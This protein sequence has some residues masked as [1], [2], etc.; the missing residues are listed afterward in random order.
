MMRRSFGLFSFLATLTSY[1]WVSCAAVRES[2]LPKDF[3]N[4]KYPDLFILG[5]QKCATTVLNKMMERHSTFCKYGDKEKHYFTDNEWLTDAKI[6]EFLGQFKK[7]G[8]DEMTVDATPSMIAEDVVPDRVKSTYPPEI[9]AKKKFVVLF[10]EPAARHYSGYQRDVR[11][12]LMLNSERGEK[13]GFAEKAAKLCQYILH[14]A[15]EAGEA[16]EF[17][18]TVFENK[19][20]IEDSLLTF[21]EWTH[22]DF[23][24]KQLKRGYFL[25]QLRNW[26]RV[27]DRSQLF[28]ISF[29]SLISNTTDVTLRLSKFLGID[30]QEFFRVSG[31]QIY[32]DGNGGKDW[33]DKV[34]TNLNSTRIVLPPEPASNHYVEYGKCK[35]DCSTY[36]HLERMWGAANAGLFDFINN[37]K[38]K[39][40]T[41]PYFPPFRSS[42]A[43]CYDAVWLN[44]PPQLK[45]W[46]NVS[47]SDTPTLRHL[48]GGRE[49]F[50][51]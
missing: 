6:E 8:K 23:G 5:A 38:N 47:H 24:Q 33:A 21:A 48:R 34:A 20:S 14:E 9:L 12:C 40:P 41:E 35:M 30:G 45:G 46:L 25:H 32:A 42:R 27:I 22:S 50:I 15:P 39:P 18:H 44:S 43:K 3:L 4:F 11:R 1:F 51:Y 29:E 37:A 7:C 31:D 2:E 13:K 19:Q 17:L 16:A 28:I 36:L 26:L 49:H 10:R